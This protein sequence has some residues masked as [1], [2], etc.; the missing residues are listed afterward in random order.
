MFVPVQLRG[1]LKESVGWPKGRCEDGAQ[2]R[3][4]Q[5]QRRVR[6]AM[7]GHKT[8]ATSDERLREV[9]VFG[10]TG[11]L[12]GRIVR[13]LARRGVTVRV[14]SRHPERAKQ[15]FRDQPPG[16]TF[17]GADVN[18]DSSVETAAAG[19]FGVVNAV[20]LYAERDRD[21]FRSVHVDAAARVAR[22]AGKAGVARLVHVSGLGADPHSSSPYIRSRGEGENIV[23]AEFPDAVIVRPAVMFGPGDAFL[24][25]LLDLLRRA[26]VFPMFGRGNTTLQPVYVE[27]V[28][29][30]IAR[31]FDTGQHPI[32]ELGGPRIYRYKELLYLL[33]DHVGARVIF[34]PVPFALWRALA[35]PAE[36]LPQ[37]PITLGQVE[38]MEIDT[39]S[40]KAVAGFPDFDIKPRELEAVL[41]TMPSRR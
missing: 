33:R 13:H 1:T 2:S 14:I 25:P 30:A 40:N 39:V 36:L 38:L 5:L 37:P 15:I 9:A 34:V 26:P 10:G 18:N 27:D 35:V 4:H 12:G 29:E 32:Y 20:S 8:S 31:L 17:V 6:L 28:A 7:Q 23:R 24:G 22:Q 16:L 11:F 41:A 3:P 21:T 19:A